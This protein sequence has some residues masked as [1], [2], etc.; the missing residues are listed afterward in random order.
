MLRENSCGAVVFF[1]NPNLNY[2]LLHYEQGHWD[3]VKGNVEFNESEKTTVIRELEEETGIIA[4]KFIKGFR[5]KVTYVYVRHGKPVFKQ[6]IFFLIETH[7]KEVSL[8][9]EHIDFKW[10]QFLDA[11]KFLTFNNSKNVLKKADYF[12]KTREFI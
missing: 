7:S 4:A 5:E 10:V 12:L 9:F 1:K 11:M 2:L 8:S 6:V 3:F